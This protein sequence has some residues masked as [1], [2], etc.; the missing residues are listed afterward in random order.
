[1]YKLKNPISIYNDL[2]Q[3]ICIISFIFIP[4]IRTGLQNPYGYGNNQIYLRNLEVKSI[5]NCTII[6]VTGSSTIFD[7]LT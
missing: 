1:M 4:W 6:L 5:Q 2:Q 7:V 3:H